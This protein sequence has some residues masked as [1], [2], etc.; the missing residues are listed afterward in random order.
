MRTTTKLL[1]FFLG[2]AALTG[3]YMDDYRWHHH[4]RPH[5]QRDWR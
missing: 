1:I 2:A 4:H 3:C 5:Y